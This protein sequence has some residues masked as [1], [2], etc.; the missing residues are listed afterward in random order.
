ME[1][2]QQETSSKP[3]KESCQEVINTLDMT[4]LTNVALPNDHSHGLFIYFPELPSQ[5][6]IS[7]WKMHGVENF[8]KIPVPYHTLPFAQDS[9]WY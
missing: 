1:N 9:Q 8:I 5:Y 4:I 3:L 2:L 7:I 6:D